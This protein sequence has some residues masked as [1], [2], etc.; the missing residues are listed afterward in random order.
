M[1]AVVRPSVLARIGAAGAGGAYANVAYTLMPVDWQVPGAWASTF[2]SPGA[3]VISDLLPV[4]QLIPQIAQNIA[5][6]T[7]LA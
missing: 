6:D 3:A 1:A 7:D 2:A 4:Q 5:A